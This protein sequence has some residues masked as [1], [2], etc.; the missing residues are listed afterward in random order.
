MET[1]STKKTALSKGVRNGITRATPIILG[2]LPIGFAFGVLSQKAGISLSN[3][4]LLSLLVYAGS[5]QL[6]A[7]GLFAAGVPMLSIIITTFIVNLRHLLMSAALSPF[8]RGWRKRELAAFAYQLT[9]ETFAVHAMQFAARM[10]SKAEIFATNMTAQ[11]AWV[12][13]TW[14]GIIAGQLITDIRPL[15]LDYALPA[16]FIALLVLQLKNRIQLLV[17][18]CT[19]LLALGLLQMGMDQW[20]IL[21][22]TVTGATL[23]LGIE[24]WI[25]Q[26]SS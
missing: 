21:A 10:P 15:A 17:A 7:V 8:L 26:R 24:Q 6:I 19:G 16:M 12:F 14:L 18:I 5:A 23:G 13:G 2:Y 11:L 1:A 20:H 22:A 9:D 25:K 3:T 4:L